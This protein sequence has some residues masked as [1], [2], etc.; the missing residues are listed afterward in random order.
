MKIT[1]AMSDPAAPIGVKMF[2]YEE[3][4]EN[5]HWGRCRR[6]S[7]LI[8]YVLSGEGYFD[9]HPVKSGEGFLITTDTLHEYHSSEHNPW[10]YFWVSFSGPE[11]A[12]VCEKYIQTDEHGIFSFGAFEQILRDLSKHIMLHS[13]QLT[14]A[15]ALGYFYLLMSCHEN[16]CLTGNRYVEQAE[17]YM[18]ANLHRRFTV[19]EIASAVGINDRYLYNLFI[20][21]RG[22]SPKQYLGA[23]KLSRGKDL[24]KNTDDSITE[25][26]IS[27]GFSDVLA[28]SRFF[29]TAEGVSPSAYRSEYRSK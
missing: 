7:Y 21:H 22:V 9:S 10:Q 19:T 12:S 16:T 6:S 28:F 2:G 26:A 23:L 1:L 13:G 18:N 29:K 8:H 27:A 17:K 3:I 20:K 11:A 24:L 25:I 14:E 15:R 5:A 4:S